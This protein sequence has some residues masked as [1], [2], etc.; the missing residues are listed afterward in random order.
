MEI[1]NTDRMEFREMLKARKEVLKKAIA[2][3]SKT[4]GAPRAE[5]A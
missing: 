4:A 5:D 1:A 2:A 3:L